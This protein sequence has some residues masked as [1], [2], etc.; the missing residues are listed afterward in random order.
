MIRVC[1][2]KRN[3]H[4]ARCRQARNVRK[5]GR[6]LKAEDVSP[7][8]V[9]NPCHGTRIPVETLENREALQGVVIDELDDILCLKHALEIKQRTEPDLTMEVFVK[10]LQPVGWNGK[11]LDPNAKT[12]E[13]KVPRL[14]AYVHQSAPPVQVPLSA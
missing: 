2:N 7:V 8:F 4:E 13:E 3:L 6:G 12:E 5:R 9:C 11:P 1:S 10:R 14:F